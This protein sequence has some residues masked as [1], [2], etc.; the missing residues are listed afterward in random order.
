MHITT[1]IDA[2]HEVDPTWDEK[3]GRLYPPNWYKHFNLYD[4][5]GKDEPAETPT[6]DSPDEKEEN[7][8]DTT[9]EEQ[10]AAEAGG[11]L[12]VAFW[13]DKETQNFR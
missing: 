12:F 1:G 9:E 8:P 6:P 3:R 2:I 4:M 13:S 5:H 11:E 10:K 7:S